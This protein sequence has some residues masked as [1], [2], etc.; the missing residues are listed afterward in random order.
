MIKVE[1]N[2]LIESLFIPSLVPPSSH[3]IIF[4]DNDFA[5]LLESKVEVA[6]PEDAVELVGYVEVLRPPYRQFLHEMF[7]V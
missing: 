6:G 3:L 1:Y 7:R 4:P 2:I 5:A